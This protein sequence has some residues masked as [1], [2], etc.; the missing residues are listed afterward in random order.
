MAIT[1]ALRLVSK[2]D[3]L[4]FVYDLFVAEADAVWSSR[5]A[6]LGFAVTALNPFVQFNDTVALHANWRQNLE[7]FGSI[8]LREV[9][10]AVDEPESSVQPLTVK[11][12]FKPQMFDHPTTARVHQ[13]IQ[14]LPNLNS[15][16]LHLQT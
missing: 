16:S 5:L 3:H 2:L 9:N 4:V 15:T 11:K 7:M 6:E 10:Y 1:F 14:P 13:L 8:R 12:P